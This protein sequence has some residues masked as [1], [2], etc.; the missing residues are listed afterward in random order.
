MVLSAKTDG[1]MGD[2]VAECVCMCEAIYRILCAM[3]DLSADDSLEFLTLK[4]QT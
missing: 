1:L 3:P 4:Y 2:M